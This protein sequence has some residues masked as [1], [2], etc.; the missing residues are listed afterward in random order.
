MNLP[1]MRFKRL[2]KKMSNK[3][4]ELRKL[5]DQFNIGL[6]EISERVIVKIISNIGSFPES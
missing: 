5:E 4:K 2:T 1:E 3:R 6:I